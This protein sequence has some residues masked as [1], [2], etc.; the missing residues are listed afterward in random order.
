M[1]DSL[2]IGNICTIVDP[3]PHFSEGKINTFN[4]HYRHRSNTF[5]SQDQI[6][7]EED[8]DYSIN[9][10]IYPYDKNKK[11]S[12]RQ[13]MV[14]VLSN[15]TEKKLRHK[16]IE[17]IKSVDSKT[18]QKEAVNHEAIKEAYQFNIPYSDNNLIHTI[19]ISFKTPKVNEITYRHFVAVDSYNGGRSKISLIFPIIIVPQSLYK[20][21]KEL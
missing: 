2:F 17:T 13:I 1:N 6:V 8:T 19:T 14:L 16:L 3:P 12:D 7:F 20:L 11:A 9:L 18:L 21:N 10:N 5:W 4:M 15:D